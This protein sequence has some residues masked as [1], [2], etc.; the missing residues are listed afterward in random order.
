MGTHKCRNCD[1]I[2]RRGRLCSRCGAPQPLRVVRGVV[3]ALITGL[4]VTTAVLAV[5]SLG[6]SAHELRLRPSDGTWAGEEWYAPD[7]SV[8]SSNPGGKADPADPAPKL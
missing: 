6:G 4:S 5:R 7:V 3:A 1:T 2:V 8:A